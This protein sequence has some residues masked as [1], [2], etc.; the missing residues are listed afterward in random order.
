[1]QRENRKWS[2]KRLWDEER[3]CWKKIINDNS[4]KWKDRKKLNDENKKNSLYE[5]EQP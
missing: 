3:N 4:T 5:N 1:M 2:D